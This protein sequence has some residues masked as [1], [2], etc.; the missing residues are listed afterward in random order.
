[1][2]IT[3]KHAIGTIGIAIKNGLQYNSLNPG[4]LTDIQNKRII[5][6]GE[7][8]AFNDVTDRIDIKGTKLWE[9]AKNFRAQIRDYDDKIWQAVEQKDLERIEIEAAHYDKLVEN[10]LCPKCGTFCYGD[11]EAN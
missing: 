10:G 6:R 4:E 11:C 1:M 8:I 7:S 5:W 2:E 3:Y 9:D